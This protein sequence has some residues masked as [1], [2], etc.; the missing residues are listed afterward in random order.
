MIEFKNVTKKYLNH[1]IFENLNLKINKNDFIIMMGPS[2]IGKSTFVKMLIA[3]EYPTDGKIIVDG[4]NI[5]GLTFDNAQIYRRKIGI[6]F[7]DYKLL[8]YKN[9][10]E[11][12]AYAMEVCD[13]TD[14]EIEKIVPKVLYDVGLLSKQSSF[15]N[16]LSGGEQQR[17]AIARALVHNP[18]LIIADE[19]TGNLDEKNSKIILDILCRLHQK[20]KTLLITTHNQFILD[21]M[22]SY[23][24]FKVENQNIKE[25]SIVN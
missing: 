2:G 3:M 10:Y 7:Q 9:V 18:S 13:Y 23:R 11:N 15:P 24:L 20:G 5:N 19:P 16:E 22:K 17:I 6:I 21:Y 12:I 25:Y 8:K 14:K 4:I 1:T